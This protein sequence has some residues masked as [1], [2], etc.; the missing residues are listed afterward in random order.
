[1]LHWKIF[2]TDSHLIEVYK[3]VRQNKGSATVDGMDIVQ[4]A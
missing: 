2:F 3:Q 1:M 4:E